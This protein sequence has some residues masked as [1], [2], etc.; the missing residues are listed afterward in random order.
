MLIRFFL[1][2]RAGRRA[3]HASRSTW[4]CSR[5]SKR[6]SRH[7]QR[8]GLLLPR[9]RL[10]VK[11]ERHFDRF[12]RVFAAH[13]KGVEQLFDRACDRDS[14]RNGCSK[15]AERLLTDEEKAQIEALGGWDKLMET[16]K[17]AA[18]GAEGA[19]PGR[20]QVDRH[21]RHLAV[22]P[23]G[24]NPEGVRIGQ[25]ECAQPPRGEG[26]GPAR[27]PQPRRHRRARHAQHQDRAAAAAPLRARGRGRGARPRRHHRLDRAQRRAARHQAWCRSGTTR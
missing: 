12:D 8:R 6:A 18:R 2:L 21:R 27:V 9:A 5:R 16:L 7:C 19:P 14:R 1:E 13:F 23:Y 3:G 25:D 26:L 22:R 15:L 20:Q 4:R 11:D 10:L 17:Q 24:Y